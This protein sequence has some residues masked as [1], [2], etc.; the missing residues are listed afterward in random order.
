[1]SVRG[2]L[3]S[4]LPWLARDWALEKAPLPTLVG[5]AFG[6]LTVASVMSFAGNDPAR[7]ASM[8][9]RFFSQVMDAVIWFAAVASATGVAATDRERGTV[10]FLFSKPIDP[11]SYYLAQWCVA[12]AGTLLLAGLGA[13]LLRAAGIHGSL[14][15]TLGA[16]ASAWL[17]LGG[18]GFLV[19]QLINRDGVLYVALIVISF[20]SRS[21]AASA[22]LPRWVTKGGV[23]LLPLNEL[24]RVRQALY[25]S[26]A[27]LTH[28][29]VHVLAY[30][31]VAFVAG[32]LVLQRRALAR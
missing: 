29:L 8:A 26:D 1:M 14:L 24:D 4:Y 16:M 30:G 19:N 9:P 20:V 11:A 27:P 12:G 3:R 15:G 31:A 23:A 32:L 10:R 28:D 18:V 22:V 7:L 13:A 5:L 6:Y 21:E 2:S 17:L 25:Q